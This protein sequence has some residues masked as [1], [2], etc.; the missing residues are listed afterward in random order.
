MTRVAMLADI[1]GNADALQSVLHEA[2]AAGAT[3]L[4]V[5]GDLVGYYYQP[6]RVLDLLAQWPCTVIRGNHEELLQKWMRDGPE[7]REALRLRYGSGL[8]ACAEQLSA[9]QIRWLGTLSHPLSRQVDG[10]QALLCHG[11][12]G[13][14]DQYVYPDRVESAIAP[15]DAAG[16]SIMWLSHTHYPMDFSRGALR[17]CNPGSVGQPRDYDP[18]AAW[19]LWDAAAGT[20]TLRR[21]IYDSSALLASIAARDPDVPYLGSVLTRTERA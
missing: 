19:A 5:L 20:V 16:A 17:V 2:R 15:E 10:V 13:N 6:R 14:I 12:P 3:E 7:A 9:A 11:H 1:H 8:Q 21:T 4:V 18:R